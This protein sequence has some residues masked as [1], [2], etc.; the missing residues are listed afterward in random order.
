MIEGERERD[1]ET[2]C[3]LRSLLLKNIKISKIHHD[4]KEIILPT[5][6]EKRERESYFKMY[7]F[8]ILL[9]FLFKIC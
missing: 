4:K 5:H 6:I 3:L 7:N 1:R 8:T 9:Y 2:F